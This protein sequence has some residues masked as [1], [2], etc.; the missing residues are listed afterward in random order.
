MHNHPTQ[1][2]QGPSA[3]RAL[4]RTGKQ[5]VDPEQK[6]VLRKAG[7]FSARKLRLLLTKCF[8][9]ATFVLGFVVGGG[10]VVIFPQVKP[11]WLGVGLLAIVALLGLGYWIQ[12]RKNYSIHNLYKGALAE[13]RI[14]DAIY[15]SLIAPNCAVAHNVFLPET[16]GDID[17]LVM[18]G[19]ILWL[20]ETKAHWLGK[21]QFPK[22]LARLNANAKALR[23]RVT[24]FQIRPILVIE[25]LP[26]GSGHKKEY[27]GVQV[28]T[29]EQL[30]KELQEAAKAG[31]QEEDPHIQEMAKYIYEGG[32][33]YK[34]KDL[35]ETPRTPLKR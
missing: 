30:V 26:S 16:R 6:L 12:V 11:Y 31:R 20:I 4:D 7:Q 25:D 9:V 32:T 28:L 27:G 5:N 19:K 18:T 23:K 15:W 1:T 17:S 21:A 34:P 13:E 22:T 35:E 10:L 24:G 8:G 29:C 3:Q 33:E 2:P 14:G